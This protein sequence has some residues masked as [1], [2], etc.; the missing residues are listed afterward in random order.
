MRSLFIIVVLVLQ[1]AAAVNSVV[2]GTRLMQ[3]V[4]KTRY[5]RTEQDLDR[6]KTVVARQ[7]YAAVVQMGLLILPLVF[8]LVGVFT[9]I[10]YPTDL[11]MI[12]VPAALILVLGYVFKKVEVAARNIPALNLRIEKQ[13]DLIAATWKK[14][15]LPDW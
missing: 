2:H 4:K 11:P 7:M 9:G 6:F 5:L 12:I 10:L 15:A 8:Y 14:K 3:Y 13:R 1:A